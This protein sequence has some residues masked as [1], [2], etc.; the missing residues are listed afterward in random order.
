MS[1]AHGRPVHVPA[2]WASHAVQGVGEETL[3][4]PEGAS[5]TVSVKLTGCSSAGGTRDA[6]GENLC[7]GLVRR[8]VP[9]RARVSVLDSSG[10]LASQQVEV[11]VER[12]HETVTLR[13]GRAAG[14]PVRVRVEVLDGAA[15][16]L[17]G[18][19]SSFNG[20]M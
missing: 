14:G 5:G 8:A 18:P 2:T 13:L 7:A 9:S 20:T 19:G 11:S 4:V 3:G 1:E 10:V 15:A 17:H 16:V 6:T 12:H